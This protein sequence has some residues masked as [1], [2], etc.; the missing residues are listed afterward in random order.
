MIRIMSVVVQAIPDVDVFLSLE[1]EELGAK[2]LFLARRGLRYEGDMFSPATFENGIWEAESRR[3]PSYQRDRQGAVALAFAE[4]WA[5]LG[6]QGLIVPAPSQ[7]PGTTYRVLSRRA[8][9]FQSEAEFQLRSGAD[10]P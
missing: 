2:L 3:Q 5:W 9:R 10:A 1:P 6:A 4:A 7:R 8:M